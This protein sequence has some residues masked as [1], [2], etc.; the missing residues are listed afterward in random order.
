MPLGYSYGL[1]VLNSHLSVGAK[2]L[3]RIVAMRLQTWASSN[4]SE[5]QAGFRQ[6]RREDDTLQFSRRVIEEVSKSKNGHRAFF[7]GH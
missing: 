6:E 2:I 1:S 5:N 3:T 7:L 4:V